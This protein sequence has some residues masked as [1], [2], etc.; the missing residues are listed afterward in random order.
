MAKSRRIRW[1]GLVAHVR[2]ERYAYT[3]FNGK[4]ESE[5]LDIDG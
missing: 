3:F 4:P 2:E 1:L 5:R